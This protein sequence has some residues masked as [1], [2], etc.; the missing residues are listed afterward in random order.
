MKKGRR[1]NMQVR[2]KVG[3]S[4]NTVFFQC[5][6]A[7]EGRK[8]GSLKRRVRRHLGR[9]ESKNCTPLWREAHVEVK[10]VKTHHA[11]TTFGSGAVEKVYAVVARS[12]F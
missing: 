4:R 12:T 1:E 10:S 11:R 9:C 6:V 5:F 8:V 3:K 2:E 7:Q